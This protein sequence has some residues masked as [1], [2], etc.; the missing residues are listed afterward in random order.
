MEAIYGENWGLGLLMSF[1]FTWGTGLAPPLLFRFVFFGRPFENWWAIGTVVAL[2]VFNLA[3]FSALGSQSKGHFSLL[4]VAFV[5]FYILRKGADEKQPKNKPSQPS[6]GS[7]PGIDINKYAKYANPDRATG[8]SSETARNE[9]QFDI[10]RYSKYADSIRA[11]S[12]RPK[13]KTQAKNITT[14]KAQSL[15][16][17]GTVHQSKISDPH[18]T[19]LEKSKSDLS[20]DTR[21]DSLKVQS[22]DWS[23]EFKILFEYDPVVKDCHDSLEKLDPQLS[24][25]FRQEVVDDRKKSNDIRDRLMAQHE[26]KMNPY[27]SDELNQAYSEAQ[28]LSP[29]AGDEFCRIIEVMGEDV[30]A[31]H[32]I[33]RMKEKYAEFKNYQ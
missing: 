26:K 32:I 11:Q 30:D 9:Y 25:Q 4:L 27:D 20:D 31:K 21:S 8:T 15:R 6:A 28:N 19:Q 33:E 22:D 12:S 16:L 14:E 7:Q 29:N 5:S 24:S 18:G 10:D 2:W 17:L 3:L 13:N 23:E 1:I